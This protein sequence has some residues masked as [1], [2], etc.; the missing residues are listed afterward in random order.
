MAEAGVL[1]GVGTRETGAPVTRYHA[2]RHNR[3][4]VPRVRFT[5][6]FGFGILPGEPDAGGAAVE[7]HAGDKV[8]SRP[9]RSLWWYAPIVFFVAAGYAMGGA[10]SFGTAFLGWFPAVSS[11]AGRL[12]LQ[13]F[14]MGMLGASMA[15]SKWWSLDHDEALNDETVRPVALDWF[16]YATTILGGGITGVVLYLVVRYGVTLV[17]TESAGDN[18]RLGAAFVIALTGGLFQFQVQA[19]LAS[20]MQ[21]IRT[22]VTAPTDQ[23]DAKRTDAQSS[24]AKDPT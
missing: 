23:E 5:L 21:K 16:G 14:G 3:L 10:L 9:C 8:P 17:V 4:G 6:G 1:C 15:C 12:C 7:T 22:Q 11:P 2:G 18:V 19:L 20:L 24:D 13:L